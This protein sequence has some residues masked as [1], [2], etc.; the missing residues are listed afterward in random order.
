MTELQAAIGRL[1]LQ[2]C[3]SGISND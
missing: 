1:Q 2:K 3:Q